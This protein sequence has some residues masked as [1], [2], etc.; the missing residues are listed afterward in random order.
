[1]GLSIWMASQTT[2]RQTRARQT[3]CVQST[4]NANNS[5]TLQELDAV[6]NENHT[7]QQELQVARVHWTELQEEFKAIREERDSL[8]LAL[9]IVS[10]DLYHKSFVMQT[11]NIRV[12]T[13][14]QDAQD[15]V[16]VGKKKKTGD[17][18][19]QSSTDTN[20]DRRHSHSRSP[21]WQ[22]SWTYLLLNL[23]KQSSKLP[24]TAWAKMFADDT[25]ITISGSSLADLA[26]NK[27]L[28]QNYWT[29]TV[30]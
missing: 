19:N 26:L 9:Q 10:K 4:Q 14:Y 20:A 21:T 18:R 3:S 16:L 17:Q 22:Y 6:R 23:Y 1:M 7:L 27:R 5:R 12:D 24:I 15:F 11:D 13:E 2:S 30:S 25:N 29:F 28:T 8:K